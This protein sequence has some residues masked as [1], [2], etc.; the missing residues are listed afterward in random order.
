MSMFHP[1]LT[2]SQMRQLE[3]ARFAAGQSSLAAMEAA[4][5]AVAEETLK[6]E[7][8]QRHAIVLVGP[9]N[10][11]GDG[12]VVARRLAE[13]G[14]AVL[15]G[16]WGDPDA[17]QGDAL[18]MRRRWS[19][20]VI[21]LDEALDRVTAEMVL[22]DALF[23]IGF[24]RPVEA[25][26]AA[27]VRQ[28]CDRACCVYAV[29]V[30]SGVDTDTGRLISD[31]VWADVTVTFGAHKL[32]HALEPAR[33]R[34]GEVVLAPIDL[35]PGPDDVAR[36]G[37]DCWMTGVPELPR[38]GPQ[39][40]K[41][42][43]GYAWV[44]SGG[45]SATGAARLAARAALR[46]GAGVVSI[47]SPPS[48]IAINAAHLT[49]IM[50]KRAAGAEDLAAYLADDRSSGMLIGPGFGI[51]ERCREAVLA[52]LATGKPLVLDA[53]ALTSFEADP[54]ALFGSIKGPVVMTP[55]EGEFR[56]LFPMIDPSADKLERVRA[57]ARLSGA[58]V[59]LKGA[60]TTIATPDGQ[61]YVNCHATPE[62]G[63]AGAGDVLAGTILGL[64]VQERQLGLSPAKAAAVAAWV[65]GEAGRR[66]GAGLIAEDLPEVYP[67]I[68]KAVAV[69]FTR[70]RMK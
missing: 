25:G 10:N 23:G 6:R 17:M 63:T 29:D 65:H 12:Y 53:D 69:R 57:A 68:L 35:A 34:C 30:P 52:L 26:L 41:F 24:S 9:G 50:V 8:A 64:M 55:H 18:T 1:L 37:I 7:P 3:Q 70:R 27:R 16:A 45:A 54:E 36:Y 62:L 14:W 44:A 39:D 13:A 5:G 4:G 58:I 15:V 32:A 46:V 19:G 49:A 2:A 67:D 42:S 61:V 40:H 66:I 20:P 33:S 51:G 60:D 21:P 59:L 56:R 22:I 43:R 31:M 28:A 11:G 47:A 48:A 38:P